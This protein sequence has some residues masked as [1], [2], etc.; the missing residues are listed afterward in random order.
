MLNF[1]RYGIDGKIS[2]TTLV[3]ILDYFEEKLMTQKM[4]S[5]SF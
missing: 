5:V 1:A 3:F 4:S 2:T